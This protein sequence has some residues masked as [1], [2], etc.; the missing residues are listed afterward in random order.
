MSVQFA[1]DKIQI[2]SFVP[3][4]SKDEL[5]EWIEIKTK[6]EI[7]KNAIEKSARLSGGDN[8]ARSLGDSSLVINTYMLL[9]PSDYASIVIRLN[10]EKN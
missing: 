8:N 1:D 4:I 3:D 6:M 5:T 2:E 9:W 10:E 7:L